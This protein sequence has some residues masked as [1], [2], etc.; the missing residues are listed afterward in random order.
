MSCRIVGNSQKVGNNL[1]VHPNLGLSKKWKFKGQLNKMQ[2]LLCADTETLQ[3][4][5]PNEKGKLQ[6]CQIPY[7]ICFFFFPTFH[8]TVS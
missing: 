1:S 5:P 7:F 4:R 6:S 2:R 8:I 3:D